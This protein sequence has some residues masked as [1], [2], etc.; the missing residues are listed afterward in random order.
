M[1][2]IGPVGN[3]NSRE[4]DERERTE[5]VQIFVSHDDQI[6]SLQFQYYQNNSLFLSDR[7]GESK[8]SKFDV[9]SLYSFS[10]LDCTLLSFSFLVNKSY[11]NF[12][13][14]STGFSV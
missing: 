7:H 14:T 13:I 12:Y 5:V 6:H 9:V 10:L 4:W 2:K 8:G 3:L 11:L 1:I